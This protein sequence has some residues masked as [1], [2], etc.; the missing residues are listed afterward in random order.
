MPSPMPGVGGLTDVIP[1]APAPTLWPEG[2]TMIK[3]VQDQFIFTSYHYIK[4]I[5]KLD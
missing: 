2:L 3:V 4:M 1:F 5:S